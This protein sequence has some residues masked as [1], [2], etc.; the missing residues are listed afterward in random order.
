MGRERGHLLDNLG[1]KHR[2]KHPTMN[3]RSGGPK[4]STNPSRAVGAGP[5][6]MG[7]QDASELH[8][9]PSTCPWKANEKIYKLTKDGAEGAQPGRVAAKQA[10]LW[11]ASPCRQLQGGCALCRYI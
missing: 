7:T 6:K 10:Q 1:L 2:S 11:P 5:C 4:A 3:P 8:L 9:G